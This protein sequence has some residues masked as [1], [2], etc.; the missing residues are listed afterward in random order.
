[1]EKSFESRLPFLLRW[2]SIE[3]DVPGSGAGS[4]RPGLR[5]HNTMKRGGQHVAGW[6]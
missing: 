3:R 6:K 5:V 2:E 1:M 4:P